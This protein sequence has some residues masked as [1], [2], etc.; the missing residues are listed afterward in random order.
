MGKLTISMAMF[1]SYVKI[2]EGIQGG[3][4]YA[5]N[6]WIA[7]EIMQVN[8]W[9]CSTKIWDLRSFFWDCDLP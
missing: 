9:E 3:K 1:N 2:P 4:K 7:A 8:I 5:V 6:I